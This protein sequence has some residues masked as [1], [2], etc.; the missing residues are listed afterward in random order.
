MTPARTLFLLAVPCSLVGCPALLSDFSIGSDGGASSDDGGQGRDGAPRDDGGADAPSVSCEAGLTACGPSCVDLQQDRGNCGSC[1]HD[2]Q[3]GDCQQG[4]CQAVT[5]A[6]GLKGTTDAGNDY[7][8]AFA[9]AVDGSDVYWAVANRALMKCAKNGCNNQPTILASSNTV[10][11]FNEDMAL[12]AT[13]VY[14]VDST[15]LRQ[16]AKTGCNNQPSVFAPGNVYALAI[17]SATVFWT[18]QSACDAGFCNLVEKCAAGGCNN[19]PTTIVSTP[20]G[21]YFPS[22]DVNATSVFMVD[23]TAGALLTCALGG[24]T[25]PTTLASGLTPSRVVVDAANAFWTGGGFIKRCAVTGCNNSPATLISTGGQGLG[26]IALD[27]TNIYWV[28]VSTGAVQSCA[29]TGCN[30]NPTTLVIGENR[31]LGIAVDATAVYWTT[32]GDG[33]VRKIA[34]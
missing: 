33:A 10:N 14:W 16:C 21:G 13:S 15:G 9:I 5:I 8:P 4:A 20:P 24:C 18:A 26:G 3:G 1:A 32:G 11:T 6:S 7:A 22:I 25:Q 19:M 2:C 31:P 12:D 28:N 27:A 23:Q 17:T 29:K 30:T 34:K